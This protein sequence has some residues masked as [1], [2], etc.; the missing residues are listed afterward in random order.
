MPVIS[1]PQTM[2]TDFDNTENIDSFVKQ[3]IRFDDCPSVFIHDVDTSS[4]WR[5]VQSRPKKKRKRF[6]P[7]R[8]EYVEAIRVATEDAIVAASH[9]QSAVRNELCSLP[10][11]CSYL[12]NSD[13]GCVKCFGVRSTVAM[14]A[15][16]IAWI[17]DTGSAHDLI[18]RHTLRADEV[19]Q[20]SNPVSLLTANGVFQATDQT[21]VNVPV[22]GTDIS[23]CVLD[24]SPAVVSV[25][26]RCV[27]AGWSF[28]WPAFSRPYFKRPDGTKVKLEVDDY[29]PYLPSPTG[30]A[31][32]AKGQPYGVTEKSG[33]PRPM[34]P[35]PAT[36]AAEEAAEVE[37]DDD[38]PIGEDPV[39]EG[40]E[41]SDDG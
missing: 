14:P 40:P 22:L 1:S 39:D 19:S 9:L 15:T 3:Q 38:N 18:S 7:N 17:A 11:E 5:S 27:D 25:G 13:I 12:R 34:V 16:E 2:C 31:M 6:T 30:V 33:V 10:V 26:Q 36:P 41:P 29:V 35:L 24:D 32:S 37:D 8:P 20:S 21:K 28:H 4:S 23:P